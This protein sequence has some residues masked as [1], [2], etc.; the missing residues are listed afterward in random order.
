[1]PLHGT[2]NRNN[3]AEL[4]GLRVYRRKRNHIRA[5]R[6]PLQA[7]QSQD[8]IYFLTNGYNSSNWSGY[9]SP[10]FFTSHVNAKSVSASSAYVPF[11]SVSGLINTFLLNQR[12]CFQELAHSLHTS[13][14]RNISQVLCHQSHAHSLQINGGCRGGPN[15]NSCLASLVLSPLDSILTKNS[16]VGALDSAPTKN[17]RGRG[18]KQFHSGVEKRLY[19][20]DSISA[21]SA[22][23]V[24][25]MP[26]ME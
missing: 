7:S 11:V 6:S 24:A 9:M 16:S 20:I 5:N 13:A 10:I 18:G 23:C 3:P 8:F 2:E 22:T 12:P 26:L 14:G 17:T 19:R 21:S 15:F 1:M 25:G 4:S